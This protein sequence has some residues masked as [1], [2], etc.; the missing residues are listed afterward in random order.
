MKNSVATLWIGPRLGPLEQL[1]A[2]SLLETGHKL[3][4]YTY[5]EVQ[6]VP[7]G[8]QVAD[9]G[10]I[11]PGPILRHK[12]TG[13]PAL[14]SDLF[15]FEL[16]RQTDATWVDLDVLALQPL[17]IEQDYVFGYQNDGILNSAI[18]KL[19]KDSPALKAM[20]T[21]KENYKGYPPFVTGRKKLK[22]QIKTLW[23]GMTL[24]ELPWGATGPIGLTHY[25]KESGEI[26][27]ALPRQSFYPVD[28]KDTLELLK[29]PDLNRSSFASDVFAVHFWASKMRELAHS[30][31]DGVIPEHSLIG[32][33]IVRIEEK[34]EISIGQR[35][36]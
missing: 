35:L 23:R 18:L 4:L 26:K 15:R 21:Y 29:N 13:S 27:Y 24:S 9:A 34:F 30:H 32:K 17:P 28:H 2:L 7:Q 11:M 20:L 25:L 10:T 8:V 14:H 16:M 5:Q 31:F 36:T 6:N 1:S 33:E 19:P 3:I 12:K 22:Y